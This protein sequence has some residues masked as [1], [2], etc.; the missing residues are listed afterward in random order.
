MKD[1]NKEIYSKEIIVLDEHIDQHNHVNNVVFLSWA[2]DLAI[3]HW[4]R[5]TE[6]RFDDDV[7]WVVIDH[8]IRYKRQAFLG[9]NITA[10]TY[11]E[12]N[13]GVKS[14]RIVEFSRGKDLL[15]HVTTKWALLKRS[16]NRPVRVPEE[17]TRLFKSDQEAMF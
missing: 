10:R 11:I 5:K 9:E 7:Y 1:Q 4:S 13:E 15:V 3:E 12:S 14:T 6:G 16:N 17:I 8:H 2:Q